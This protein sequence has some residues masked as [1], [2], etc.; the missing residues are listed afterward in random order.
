VPASDLVEQLAALAD[1]GLSS[2]LPPLR[3]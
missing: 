2:L 3:G 1:G